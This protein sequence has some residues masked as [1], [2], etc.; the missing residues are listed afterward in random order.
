MSSHSTKLPQRRRESAPAF[1]LALLVATT[2][3]R[4]AAAQNVLTYHNDNARTGQN[5]QERILTPQRVSSSFFGKL[6]VIPVDGKVDAEPLYVRHLAI[7]GPGGPRNVLFVATEHGSVYALDAGTGKRF[8]RAR[9]LKSGETPS[10]PRNCTQVIPEI[11]VT[12]TPVI[13]LSSGPHG[14][15]YVVAMSR[16]R[17]GRYYQRLHA[18]DLTTGAEEFGGP[19]D[20]QATFPGHGPHSRDGKVV[21]DPKQ[22]EER[23]ALLLDHGVI[24]TAWASHCDLEPYN[25]WIMGYDERNLSQVSVLN[26]TPNGNE[27]AIWQSGNGPAADAEGN[28]YLLDGNGAFDA[29]TN[30]QDFPAQGDFGNAFLKLAVID[31]R[32]TVADYFAVSNIASENA[33]DLDLGSGGPLVLPD[34]K[35]ASGRV[36]HLAVGAGKDRNI[37]L[38]NRDSMGK[39][40]PGGN[41]RNAYQVVQHVLGDGEFASPAYFDGRLY[42]GAVDDHIKEF[43][44][45]NGRLED[46]PASES[47]TVF[48]YP[49]ATPSISADGLRN[50]IVWAAEHGDR[51][52]LRAYD[53]ND[54]SRELYNS[55]QQPSGRDYFGIGNKFITPMIAGGR[56]YV[57]T[58]SGVAVFGLLPRVHPY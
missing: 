14:T 12:S 24:Y 7:P 26:L 9:L 16:D 34:L 22:Y 3:A 31:G 4:I 42:Y 15:V 5:L 55:N 48:T 57:G 29:K 43:R 46:S 38:V 44:F 1:C 17:Q 58:T 45:V 40:D 20:I 51:A 2:I 50:G 18:L 23:A 49:G 10:D 35:D 32:L 54:L 19:A 52:V 47:P 11:G 41:N 37:Y 8:W 33:T 56:V 27:G 30:P 53:A 13:D 39:F 36:L 21:F 6:F 28:I 25:G